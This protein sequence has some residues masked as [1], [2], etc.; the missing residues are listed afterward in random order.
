MTDF[1]E[2]A[3]DESAAERSVPEEAAAEGPTSETPLSE[4]SGSENSEDSRVDTVG[5]AMPEFRMDPLSGDWVIIAGGRQSRPSLPAECPFC[6]GGLEAPEAYT[7]KA[8]KNRWPVM[9]SPQALGLDVE[10]NRGF[11]EMLRSALPVPATAGPDSLFFSVPAIGEAE[12]V[13]YTPKHEGSLGSLSDEELDALWRLWTERTRSL[14]RLEHV[15]YVLV[16]ENRGAEVG[17]TIVHPHGQIYGFPFVPPRIEKEIRRARSLASGAG[18]GI[19]CL[20]CDVL[21]AEIAGPRLVFED[22]HSVAYVPYASAWP[23]ALCLVPKRHVGS[24]P[25]LDRDESVSLMKLL[26][27]AYAAA[28]CIF[29]RPLPTMMAFLQEPFESAPPSEKDDS[30]AAGLGPRSPDWHMRIEIVSPLRKPNTLRYVA[31]AEVASSVYQNP[32]SPEE[33]ARAWR[34]AFERIGRSR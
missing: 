31:G 6:I 34:K 21:E 14:A 22:D 4:N 26:R 24:L 23:F 33:A 17:V 20:T 18:D 12:V 3:A 29:D 8:F 28:D 10:E 32:V 25:D 15:A 9:R 2:N 19:R 30:S 7:V 27:A 16:F 1:A 5:A 11:L 13:L